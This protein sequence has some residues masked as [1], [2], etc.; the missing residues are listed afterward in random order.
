MSL[1]Y[2]YNHYFDYHYR[3]RENPTVISMERD[4]FSWNT[5][6]PSA[7]ICPMLKINTAKLESYLDE[8]SD[9]KN[10]SLFYNFMISLAEATYY[11]LESVIE[12]E[13]VHPEDYLKLIRKFQFKF[14]PTVSNSALNEKQ[15]DL[16]QSYTE[17][18]FCYSFNSHL[19]V[20]NSLE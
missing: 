15:F 20:Y 1:D 17:M 3:Y 19:A 4:R 6:F 13:D 18:G 16:Q 2:C 8:A 10:K 9:I 5:S 12:Y 7:T 11:N 14:K